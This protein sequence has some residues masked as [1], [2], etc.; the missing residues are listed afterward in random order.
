MLKKSLLFALMMC[1]LVPLAA[2][3]C[4]GQ[5][6]E[7][8]LVEQEVQPDATIDIS[9]IEPLPS[10][11]E[12]T[13][14]DITWQVLEVE[15]LGESIKSPSGTLID[16]VRGK[17]VSIR[18][19]VRNDGADPVTIYDFSV[20]DSKGRVFNICLSAYEYFVPTDACA[21][22]ELTPG[23][24]YEFVAPFDVAPDSKGLIIEFTDLGDQEE[25]SAYVSLGM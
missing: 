23:I 7:I 20:I 11:Q 4:A 16:A 5:E 2:I 24:E 9:S 22:V 6:Q 17:F 3:G 13:V 14:G 18:F 15:E 19:R 21:L 8:D 12:V 1:V 10:D 25:Q